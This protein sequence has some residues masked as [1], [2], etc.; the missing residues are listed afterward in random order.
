MDYSILMQN[1]QNDIKSDKQLNDITNQLIIK[2]RKNTA[3]YNDVTE[4]SKHLGNVTSKYLMKY[5]I[6]EEEIGIYAEEIVAPIYRSMQKTSI[7][8]SKK[9]QQLL[10]DT[11]GIGI[12]PANVATDES[13][14]SHIVTRFKETSNIED[15]S[16]LVGENVAENIARGAVTDSLKANA[17]QLD[18]VGFETYVTRSGS[19]CCKW[20]D[21]MTGT[22]PI[23]DVPSD[24]WRVHKDCTCS[25]D[26]KCKGK[27]SRITFTTSDSGKLTKNTE[28][29]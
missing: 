13:R 5:G 7:T 21:S 23:N 19:G 18:D 8:A 25:F 29:I 15:V 4:Y 20:C 10:N 9:V 22:Y 3:T 24:F 26:Y 28:E 12:A 2:L 1:I 16:F 27:N 17:K 11:N 6:P 14:I